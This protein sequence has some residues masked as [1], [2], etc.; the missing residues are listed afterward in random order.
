[1]SALK[2]SPTLRW[3]HRETDEKGDARKQ[4]VYRQLVGKLLWIDRADFRCTDMRNIKSIQRYLRR[5]SI[6]KL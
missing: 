6:W 1:M 5:H 3:E 2:G 4:R